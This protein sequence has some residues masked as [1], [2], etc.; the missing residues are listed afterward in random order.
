MSPTTLSIHLHRFRSVTV[1]S[2]SLLMQQVCR[3]FLKCT[4]TAF[5]WGRNHS[6]AGTVFHPTTGIDSTKHSK[7]TIS[8]AG[9]SNTRSNG[10]RR[11]EKVKQLNGSD[12]IHT[13]WILAP[14]VLNSSNRMGRSQHPGI[15][16]GLCK[17]LISGVVPLPVHSESTMFRSML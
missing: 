1:S 2:L 4:G 8:M 12:R 10:T 16:P 9:Q 7:V 13:D 14:S 5:R 6:G 11:S 3:R 17:H 15:L